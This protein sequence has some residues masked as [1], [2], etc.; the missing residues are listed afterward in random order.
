MRIG[1]C[2]IC[3]RCQVACKSVI[4]VAHLD[5]LHRFQIVTTRF[6]FE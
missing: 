2:E 3:A 4:R 6:A 1:L 5:R